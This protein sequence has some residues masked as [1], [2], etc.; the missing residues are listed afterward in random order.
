VSTAVGR[1]HALGAERAGLAWLGRMAATACYA[2]LA[3]VVIGALFEGW[4]LILLNQYFA[5]AP[6]VG[7]AGPDTIVRGLRNAAY[8]ALGVSAMVVVARKGT[9]RQFLKPVDMAFAA[10]LGALL[11]AA[12]AGESS[13]TLTAHGIFVYIRGAIVFYAVRAL[14]PTWTSARV[15]VLIVLSILIVFVGVAFAQVYLGAPV[16]NLLG[17]T[18]LTWANQHRAQALLSHPNHLGHVAG[19]ALLGVLA[20]DG[21]QRPRRWWL[22]FGVLALGLA[23]SQSRESL[24][25]AIVGIVGL[26][27]VYAGRRRTVILALAMVVGITAVTWTLQPGS[28]EALAQKIRGVISAVEVPSGQVPAQPCDPGLEE[29]TPQGIPSRSIRVLYYQQGVALW[30]KS[31][32]LGYG[33]GQ[34]GGGVASQHNPEWYKNARFGPDGFDLHNFEATQVDSFWLH[35]LVETGAVGSAAYLLWLGSIGLLPAR[36]AW[37]SWK[38]PAGEARRQLPDIPRALDRYVPAALLFACLIAGLS[39]ALEDP[40]FGPLLF[41]GLGLAWGMRASDPARDGDQ[42]AARPAA[43]T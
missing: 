39:P 29:C 42:P 17:L 25:A 18:D 12:L 33:V 31:P 40:V 36:R 13:L 1:E 19:L 23:L 21:S 28:W 41:G 22:L 14:A 5:D 8:I 15:L 7:G 38:Q 35:L 27:V 34:F 9:L 32:L 3:L 26:A 11:L 37:R 24:V 2:M 4:L 30:L 6:I 20:V 43:D 16:Y 10:L